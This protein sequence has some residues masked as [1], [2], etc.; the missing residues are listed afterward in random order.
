MSTLTATLDLGY[1][2]RL[3]GDIMLR[4][5][6][7]VGLLDRFASIP[8][9]SGSS[10]R[11]YVAPSLALQIPLRRNAFVGAELRYGFGFGSEDTHSNISAFAAVGYRF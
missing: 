7:G 4:P 10:P 3:G 1:R 9:A 5:Y 8:G 2:L 11:F 6:V